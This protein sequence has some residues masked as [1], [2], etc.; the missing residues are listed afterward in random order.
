MRFTATASAKD[1]VHAAKVVVQ[2]SSELAEARVYLDGHLDRTL[3][4]TGKSASFDFTFPDLG[5]GRSVSVVASDQSGQ[6]SLPS[7]IKLPGTPAKRGSLRAI[8]IGVDTYSDASINKLNFAKSDAN[9]LGQAIQDS[10]T[11]AFSSVSVSTLLDSE[12]TP[13][14]VLAAVREAAAQTGP[15]DT[16]IFSFA[17]HAIG[18]AAVGRPDVGLMLATSVSRLNDLP[19]TSV[20]WSDL[21]DVVATARG[22]I[23]FILDACH[24]GLAGSE[25]FGTNDDVVSSLFTRG[26]GSLVVLAASKGRQLSLENPAFGGGLFTSAIVE[27]L[28]KNRALYDTDH[29]G[30]IDLSELYRGV[31]QIVMQKSQNEQTPWLARSGIVGDL[32]LF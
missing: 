11:S 1:G 26:G 19:S 23:I 8:A 24:A 17:G 28:T 27:V 9:K 18:G 25:K 22:K 30:L 3:P 14:R 12:V 16:L 5:G 2:G 31:K 13:N 29:S 15:D 21:T 32:S 10:A 7:S 4:A 20:K 6:L